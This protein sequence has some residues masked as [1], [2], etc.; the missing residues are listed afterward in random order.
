MICHK[1]KCIFIHIPRCGGT[2]MEISMVGN[3][4]HDVDASTKHLIAST[5][6]KIYEPYWNHY[7]K[8]SFV[9]NPWDRMVSLKRFGNFYGINF[10]NNKI[11]MS[12]YFKKFPQIEVDPKSK[13]HN[14][15]FHPIANAVYLNILNVDLDFIGR[16]E[17]INEDFEFV[18][19]CIGAST[20]LL[21]LKNDTAHQSQHKHY[22]EYYDDETREIVSEKYAK[23]IKYFGYKF[24]E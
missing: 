13:V 11:D 20:S 7:F 3:N 2:S 19:E 8:F 1:Y 24:G 21:P 22:T 6:K 18:C 10:K 9:R 4:W 12:N 17:N 16:F 5:A 15:K 23:D 14:D